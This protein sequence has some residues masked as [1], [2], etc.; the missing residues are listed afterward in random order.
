[1]R[2][3]N[4]RVWNSAGGVGHAQVL[5]T[6]SAR[7]RSGIAHREAQAGRP[8]PVVADHRQA[9]QIQLADQARQVRDMPVEAVRLLAGR[10]LGQA[11]ADHVGDDD[12]VSRIHQR[13]DDVAIEEAPG[14]IAVQQQDGIAGALIDVMHPPAIDPRVTGGEGPSRRETLRCSPES[15]R[16]CPVPHAVTRRRN[17]QI[18]T[19]L[20][21][22][23]P[24]NGSMA[25][26]IA[27]ASAGGGGCRTSQPNQQPVRP[28]QRRALRLL[29]SGRQPPV[30]SSGASSS[31]ANDR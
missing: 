13:R 26:L 4:R 11:E 27:A 8:T 12:A 7:T 18:T 10:L 30:A 16:S 28:R 23:S 2:H 24:T 14:R 29:D 21:I 6:V 15:S 20:T 22:T 5:M 9:L 25:A 17:A 1:M 3:G 31:Q 19:I